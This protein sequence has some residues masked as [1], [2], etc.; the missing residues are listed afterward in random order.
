MARILRQTEN[1]DL[2]DITWRNRFKNL[3][4]VTV[5]ALCLFLLLGSS[6][7]PIIIETSIRDTIVDKRIAL[8][9]VGDVNHL[10][11]IAVIKNA[12]LP[13]YLNNPGALRPSSIPEVNALAIGK[14][15]VASGHFL[16]FQNP[17][18]GWEALEIVL[19]KVYWQKTIAET[20]SRF[21]PNFENNTDSYIAK[22]CSH[23]KCSP[24]TQ[25]KNINIE[26]LKQIISKIEGY[27]G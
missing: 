9:Q 11:E 18:Q 7:S 12:N 14:V 27:N 21:A 16:M 5:S 19:K 20:I 25:V 17:K 8:L 24:N 26:E 15:K 4:L 3:S 10:K 22:V 6:S 2:I 1:L 13:T 23:L